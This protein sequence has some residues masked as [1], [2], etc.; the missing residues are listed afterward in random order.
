M[1]E[2][3]TLAGADHSAAEVDVPAAF[4][5]P[6]E[7]HGP[8]ALDFEELL[9]SVKR[10]ETVARIF[11]RG[12]LVAEREQILAELRTLVDTNGQV[13]ADPEAAIGETSREA[14]AQALAQR[15]AQVDATMAASA[16]WVRFRGMPSDEW[17]KFHAAHFPKGE[18]RDVTEF[19]NRLIAEVA[20]EPTLTIPQIQRMRSELG[21]KQM[22]TMADEAWKSCNEGG[23]DVPK[24]PRSLLSLA[25]Q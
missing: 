12:D 25:Q 9:S 3:Q 16:R 17:V 6:T 15:L 7:E 1:T 8:K 24:S 21:A 10:V 22:M 2:D 13:I 14:R 4:Q 5:K 11:L 23:V 20:I 18:K 19:N